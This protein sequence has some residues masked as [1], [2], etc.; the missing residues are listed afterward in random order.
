[1]AKLILNAYSAERNGAF[2]SVALL[3]GGNPPF[4]SKIVEIKTAADCLAAFEAYKADAR[5]TGKPLAVSMMMGRG[6]RKPPGFNK[7]K[8]VHSYDTVN[9]DE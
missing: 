5:A 9:I 4:P 6:D 2:L 1:M 3:I 8:A 7:I